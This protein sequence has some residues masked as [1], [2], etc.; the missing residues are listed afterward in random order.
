MAK[1]EVPE[2]P[3][4][5]LPFS[6]ITPAEVRVHLLPAAS[7]S[8]PPEVGVSSPEIG[9]LVDAVPLIAVNLPET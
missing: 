1:A 8:A 4:I 6:S 9:L 3:G 7:V 5:G 2:P